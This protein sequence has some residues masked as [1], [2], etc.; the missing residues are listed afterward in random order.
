MVQRGPVENVAHGRLLEQGARFHF[1]PAATVF[2]N[3]NYR[4][5]AFCRDRF[6]HGLS[7]AR[8]R[9]VDEGSA[10]RWCA[11]ATSPLLPFVLTKRVGQACWARH[12]RPFMRAL[13]FT[14]TF[15]A[16]WSLGEA[17]GYLTGSEPSSRSGP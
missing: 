2:Q 17:A 3:K 13:P 4:L 14:F 12:A 7:Y 1:E 10:K 15:L 6:E 16:A 9:V 5:A 8:R 11:L